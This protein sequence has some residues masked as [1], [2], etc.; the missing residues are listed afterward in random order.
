MI[1]TPLEAVVGALMN[2]LTRKF[3]YSADEFALGLR[4]RIAQTAPETSEAALSELDDMGDRLG[5]AL[6][7]LHVKNLSTVW[8]D[9]L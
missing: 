2:A 1:L 4:G 3:E 8:V 7:T 9:W 5:R 6:V